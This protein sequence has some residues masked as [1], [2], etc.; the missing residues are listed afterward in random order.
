MNLTNAANLSKKIFMP[1]FVIS[2][3]ALL[4]FLIVFRY[5]K[6][7]V[8]E[9][10]MPKFPIQQP[11]FN[12]SPL[13]EKPKSI[14]IAENLQGSQNKP[15]PFFVYQIREQNIDPARAKGLATSFG[16]SDQPET[17]K[18]A[19]LGDIFRWSTSEA[20]LSI[21]K[22]KLTYNKQ[23]SPREN[24]Q[25]E[26]NLRTMEDLKNYI[27]QFLEKHQLK[28]DFFA[29]ALDNVIFLK[30]GPAGQVE[31]VSD[32]TQADTISILLAFKL[33]NSPV[34]DHNADQTPASL[35]LTKSGDI[36]SLSY[37][38]LPL[39]QPLEKYPIKTI[40]QAVNEILAGNGILADFI[41][42]TKLTQ[43]EGEAVKISSAYLSSA[44]LAYY[45]PLPPP[46]VLQ[47]V[48]VFKGNAQSTENEAGQVKML[49]PAVLEK[50]LNQP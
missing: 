37:R 29:L 12:Q 21:N 28:N 5:R 9:I 8:E 7:R 3:C 32:I 48:Y 20:T 17:V 27:N 11:L 14:Q 4:V 22:F 34:V 24:A 6:T 39:L 49:I 40:A 33:N 47:P 18:D 13:I 15:A 19:V 25:Q 26:T 1:L 36:I 38:F 10:I 23:P 42:E 35:S 45:L 46:Q 41:P 50:F 30:K 16:L 43:D 2:I 31:K 44:D